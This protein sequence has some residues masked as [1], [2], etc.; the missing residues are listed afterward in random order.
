MAKKKWLL[1]FI[2]KCSRKRE[3]DFVFPQIEIVDLGNAFCKLL[4]NEDL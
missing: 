2:L 3:H 1:D 4:S